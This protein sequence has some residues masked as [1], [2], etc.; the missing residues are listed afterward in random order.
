MKTHYFPGIRVFWLGQEVT[1]DFVTYTR[2]RNDARAPSTAELTLTS[3]NNRYVYTVDDL[4]R[5]TEARLADQELNTEFAETQSFFAVRRE[6]IQQ[7]ARTQQDAKAGKPRPAPRRGELVAVPSSL[8]AEQRAQLQAA[9]DALKE[10]LWSQSSTGL[11]SST[12]VPE[13]AS[14]PVK[15]AVLAL[16]R[17]QRAYIQQSGGNSVDSTIYQPKPGQCTWAAQDPVRVAVRDPATQEWYWD[18]SGF[19][20]RATQRTDENNQ[21]TVTIL[22]EDVLRIPAR[23][24]MSFAPGIFN[25]V[26][27]QTQIDAA[28]L[29]AMQ[30]GLSDLSLEQL[31]YTVFFGQAQAGVQIRS[32]DQAILPIS[33]IT[34]TSSAYRR[35]SVN[36]DTTQRADVGAVL[37]SFDPKKSEQ[38]FFGPT[39]FNDIP[40]RAQGV[41]A[42]VNTDLVSYQ[43]TV[44]TAVKTSDLVNMRL[45]DT[46]PDFA[47]DPT[48]FGAFDLVSIDDVITAIGS[49]PDKYPVDFG[50]VYLTIPFFAQSQ[51]EQGILLKDLIKSFALGG[52]Y[53]TRLDYLFDILKRVDFT[54]FATGRGD[55]CVEFPFYDTKPSDFGDYGAP[56]E[57]TTDA[58]ITTESS[59][60]DSKVVN[61]VATQFYWIDGLAESGKHEVNTISLSR[62]S[63]FLMYGVRYQAVEPFGWISSPETAELFLNVRLNQANADADSV[64]V[65]YLPELSIGPNR[66][67][68]VQDEDFMAT[69]RSSTLRV[70]WNAKAMSMS[71]GVNYVRRLEQAEVPGRTSAV[72]GSIG[73]LAEGIWRPR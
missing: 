22:C 32:Q 18:F 20:T 64:Q 10:E 46:D 9:T 2:N 12:V 61:Q 14:D 39:S 53:S 1:P 52:A 48:R 51:V 31:V 28:V 30:D 71:V 24:R 62:P 49:R 15:E 40:S 17:R 43:R 56:W 45:P 72:Y 69:V 23:A 59:I 47:D 5:F 63:S 13:P 67:I 21:Q 65:T 41:P 55:I 73:L 60:D 19:V 70:D 42:R 66:P 36:G 37:G 7:V 58:L 68:H 16:R 25:Q 54:I 3:P 8:S 33:T 26:Q 4:R 11:Y 29:S 38:F 6:Q 34:G 44:D 35:F 50:G 27:L 57:I